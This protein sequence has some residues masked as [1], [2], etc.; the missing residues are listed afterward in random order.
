MV[1]LHS[2]QTGSIIR[3]AS[4]C[5]WRILGILYSGDAM[6]SLFVLFMTDYILTYL[7]VSAGIIEEANPILVWLPELPFIPG[8]IIRLLM[9][10]MVAYIP[11]KLIRAGRI[12]PPLAKA[13][14]SVAFTAN[15]A[16]LG[17]HLYW[18]ITYAR[19][20]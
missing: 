17:V 3:L 5:F 2:I 7:G 20:A 18:I 19:I 4:F 10:M 9:F 12:K 16:I 1:I 15:T 8:F 13:Y 11:I 14:Y 6:R